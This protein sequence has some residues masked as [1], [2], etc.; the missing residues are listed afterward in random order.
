MRAAGL[1]LAITCSWPVAGCR[2]AKP[3]EAREVVPELEL[4][5]VA[6]RLY[7]DAALRASGT[8]AVATYRRDTTGVTAQDL[9][10]TLFSTGQLPVRISAPEGHGIASARTFFASGG[11]EA[12]RDDDVARTDRARFEPAPG[13]RGV[14]RGDDPVV[15][16]GKGY[17]LQGTGFQLDPASG[18]IVLR[19]GARLVAGTAGEK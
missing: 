9:Q 16:T 3:R 2:P 1:L 17:R 7:R 14:V 11:V 5:G 18:E 8:A 13:G 4:E 12:V 19:G 10:A 15:V 6:F